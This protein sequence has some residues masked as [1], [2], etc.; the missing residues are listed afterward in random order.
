MIRILRNKKFPCVLQQDSSDCAAATISTILKYYK[1]DMTIAEL[2][3]ILGTDMFGTTVKGM[4]SCL[5]LLNFEVKAVRCSLQSLNNNITLPCI[6]QTVTS[7]GMSHFVVIYKVKKN[8][9]FIIADP[10]FGIRRVA[11]CDFEKEFNG[12]VLLMIP[13]SDFEKNK[14]SNSSLF[15]LFTQLVLPQKQLFMTAILASIVLS[16]IGLIMSVS[17]KVLF[18]EI[19]PHQLKQGLVVFLII[20]G[21][22]N[23]VQSIL[24]M[25]RSHVLLF[26]SRKVDIPVLM[27]YYDHILHQPYKF[28]NTR[29]TG[30]I[31]TRFQDAM[32]IKDVFTSTTLSL[33]LDISLAIISGIIL[34]I[35]N[36]TLFT[37]IIIMVL[38][39]IALIYF[40]KK[41]YKMINYEEM[42]A[43]S[44]LNSHLIESINN[45]DT[46]KSFNS[47]SLLI[48]KLEQKFVKNLQIDYKSGVIQNIH[49]FI[50][51]LI[52]TIGNLIFMGIGAYMIIDS[53]I[54]IGDLLLFQSLSSY[55]AEPIQSIVSLQMT[56]QEVQIAFNRL[57]ELMGLPREDE[58]KN[59][60]KN[61]DL[62]GDII[63]DNVSFSYGVRKPVID[64]LNLTIKKGQKIALVGESG[65]GKTTLVKLLIKF[66]NPS[67]GKITIAGHDVSNIDQYFLRRHISYVPQDV[68]LFTG[69]IFEN[70][71][72][73][74]EDAT[75]EDVINACKKAGASSFIESL[76]NRYNT[77][78]EEHGAN[79]SSGERQRLAIARTLLDDRSIYIF[80]EATSNLDSFS[81]M[82]IQRLIF[83]EIKDKTTIII[84]HRISTI[85]NCDIICYLE[86]GKIIEKG[87]H[88]EL[89]TLNKK[90]AQMIKLQHIDLLLNKNKE[91]QNLE[92]F[93]YE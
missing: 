26:L 72:I 37:I 78:V 74:N 50:S 42:E 23:V 80:D 82:Q 3:D 52:G 25:F 66:M 35:L 49:T 46:I 40:F 88:E 61:I 71:V 85:V 30:D 51:T 59:K 75:I 31:I 83:D 73:G 20:I 36:K 69:T 58:D 27:G 60:L 63:F 90:Y 1:R 62:C 22:V 92:E 87:T 56:F 34:Y 53:K 39:N 41:P 38:I 10:I 86:K 24:G 6:V 84:A 65:A 16:V 57:N 13:K 77:F 8:R 33:V 45:I 93:T 21:V 79:F 15:K 2:R 11:E 89:M 68:Q 43:S 64:N 14:S 67:S 18:D 81:E 29:K 47:E 44:K 54:T 9:I 4:V 91:I 19:I 55:F 70:L 48:E 32:T 76:P 28:F 7:N 12:I 5:E 17:T